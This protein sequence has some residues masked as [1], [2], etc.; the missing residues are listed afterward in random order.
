MA[1]ASQGNICTG[2]EFF[3]GY[4]SERKLNSSTLAHIQ[5]YIQNNKYDST[6]L[7]LISFAFLQV[8]KIPFSPFVRIEF[9]QK[10]GKTH[11]TNFN[12]A[13]TILL[14]GASRL[15]SGG[16]E[17]LLENIPIEVVTQIR[18]QEA[19]GREAGKLAVLRAPPGTEAPENQRGPPHH[20][21]SR[22]FY[23]SFP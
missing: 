13:L 2:M 12:P 18:T 6:L 16:P 1:K 7:P 17:D 3:C 23:K 15:A 11:T 10:G 19:G 20:G 14:N 9:K 21:D 5:K 4:P 8:I 22:T